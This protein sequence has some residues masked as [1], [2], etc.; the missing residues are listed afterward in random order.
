DKAAQRAADL[1]KQLLGFSRRQAHEIHPT[2]INLVIQGMDSLIAR[3][4]TPE[5]EVQHNLASD[6]W[7]TEIDSGDLEDALLNLI[8]NA[9]D[10][11]P[12]RGRL[13]IETSNKVFDD[14]YAETNPTITPGEYIEL[15]VSDSGRG[16]SK[17]DLDHIF[18]P[19]FTTKPQGKG[20]GL[21][22]SMV[23]GFVKRSK[24][25]IKVYSE[26]GIGTTIRCYLP[27]S[28]SSSERHNPPITIENQLPGGNEL[29]LV[30]D[31]EESLIEVAQHH[32]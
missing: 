13:T 16:I 4:I 6:L 1:T 8:L 27:R 23:F 28:T 29:I 12:E 9:R 2:N 3:S 21:G 5:V 24:G 7:L 26:V 10:A 18:E 31:D 11:M 25:Q 22:L 32:L 19:F 30:V 20:T 17:E 14:A 15:T